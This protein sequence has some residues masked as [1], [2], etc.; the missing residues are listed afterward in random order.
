MQ[1]LVEGSGTDVLAASLR[2]PDAHRR[3]SRLGACR[4]FTAAPTVLTAVLQHDV[5]DR[6]AVEF[7]AAV[8]RLS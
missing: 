1:A 2:T 7:E 5:S 8:A 4:Y 3:P 6:S